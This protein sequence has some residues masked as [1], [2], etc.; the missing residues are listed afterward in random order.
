[1]LNVSAIAPDMPVASATA[2]MNGASFMMILRWTP[3]NAVGRG[4]NRDP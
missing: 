1:M 3:A 4:F 2:V